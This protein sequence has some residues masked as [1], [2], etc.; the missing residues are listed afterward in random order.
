M[1]WKDG[2]IYQIYPRSFKDSNGDGVGDLNGITQHL[3]YL[4]DGTPKSL[5]IDAIWISPFFRSPMKDF[6]YDISDYK[7]TDPIFGTLDDFKL[8]TEEA[9]KRNIRIIIDMVLNP[10]ILAQI[11]CLLTAFCNGLYT[12]FHTQDTDRN[13]CGCVFSHDI[14]HTWR[15]V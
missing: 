13:R 5:E 15:H 3:D 14:L 4:S 12:V 8:L 11:P 7:N 1:W 2:V 10:I 6:G 9:H